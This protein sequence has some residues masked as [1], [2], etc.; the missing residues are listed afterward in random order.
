MPCP[1]LA[2]RTA[3][4]GLSCLPGY[5]CPAGTIYPNQYPCPAGTYS[6]DITITTAAQCLT[7]PAGYACSAGTNSITNVM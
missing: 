5:Y 3:T 7:C 2:Q 1:F 4:S 6:D